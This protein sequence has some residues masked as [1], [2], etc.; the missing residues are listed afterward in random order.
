[1]VNAR[2]PFLFRGAGL[3]VKA[4]ADQPRVTCAA[5]VHALP[6]E[7]PVRVGRERAQRIG[8]EGTEL[9]REPL[10]GGPIAVDPGVGG[11]AGLP[12]AG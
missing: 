12:F 9:E 7:W 1:M 8:P 11:I 5:D 4:M 3:S 6:G 10:A 2:W